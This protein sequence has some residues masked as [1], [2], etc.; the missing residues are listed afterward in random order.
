MEHRYLNTIHAWCFLHYQTCSIILIQ[1]TTTNVWL[2]LVVLKAVPLDTT[3]YAHMYHSLFFVHSLRQSLNQQVSNAWNFSHIIQYKR[4]S[5][6]VL[7][8]KNFLLTSV[9]LL[10]HLSCFLWFQSERQS[11]QNMSADQICSAL[12]CQ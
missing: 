6:C 4:T 2:E 5:E 8:S 7:L 11:I 3:I 10:S 12:F 9:I 1:I